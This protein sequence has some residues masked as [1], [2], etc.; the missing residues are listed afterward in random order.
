MT[1][2]LKILTALFIFTIYTSSAGEF[3]PSTH[4][5][6]INP[7]NEDHQQADT[8][9]VDRISKIKNTYKSNDVST[10]NYQLEDIPKLK[11]EVVARSLKIK[12]GGN[13]S[14]MD[15][16]ISNI[17]YSISNIDY[18]ITKFKT[19]LRD[20]G[21]SISSHGL[22]YNLDAG[23]IYAGE[24]FYLSLTPRH[25]T[26]NMKCSV[27]VDF[28]DGTK[29][30]NTSYREA[31]VFGVNSNNPHVYKNPGI[32]TITLDDEWSLGSCNRYDLTLQALV[33]DKEKYI[34]LKQRKVATLSTKSSKVIKHRQQD[35]YYS[36]PWVIILIISIFILIFNKTRKKNK[37]L[38]EMNNSTKTKENPNETEE[39]IVNDYFDMQEDLIDTETKPEE[40]ERRNSIK[41]KTE[42]E[43]RKKKAQLLAAAALALRL[44]KPEI[45]P[46]KGCRVTDTKLTSKFLIEWTIYYIDESNPIARQWFRVSIG[47]KYMNTRGGQ[48]KFKWASPI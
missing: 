47:T 38:S 9:Q 34:S 39:N 23:L 46:P 15:Y 44:T 4:N 18:L 32:Y 17:D 36:R 28:G 43:E 42:E 8:I 21:G 40:E 14:N 19:D 10:Y 27:N 31:I 35:E 20:I 30:L 12:Y 7:N 6:N 26:G 3:K 37:L 25:R 24:P 2:I 13:T 41:R 5:W 29:I 1:S 22:G 11:E 48:F 33:I 45:F 16:S